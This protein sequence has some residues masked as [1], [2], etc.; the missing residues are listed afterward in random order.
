MVSSFK[1]D[2]PDCDLLDNETRCGIAAFVILRWMG[3]N[4]S[5]CC[6]DCVIRYAETKDSTNKLL[7]Y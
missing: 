1:C 7:L 2:G 6:W 4:Y 3:V 5:F